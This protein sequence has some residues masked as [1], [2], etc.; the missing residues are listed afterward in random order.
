VRSWCLHVG[1]DLGK[2]HQM[3]GELMPGLSRWQGGIDSEVR[4]TRSP[5]PLADT[6]LRLCWRWE[7]APWTDICVDERRPRLLQYA[8]RESGR[9]GDSWSVTPRPLRCHSNKSQNTVAARSGNSGVSN[10]IHDDDTD[11]GS[12]LLCALDPRPRR[13]RAE[14]HRKLPTAEPRGHNH[15]CDR[16]DTTQDTPHLLKMSW[17]TSWFSSSRNDKLSRGGALSSTSEAFSLPVSSP[18]TATHPDAFNSDSLVMNE[19]DSAG[20]PLRYSYPPGRSNPYG[21][22]PPGYALVFTYSLGRLP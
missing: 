1:R 18:T 15:D 3:S 4:F 2:S 14:F 17:F 9:R 20:G 5:R 7:C 12:S 10:T 22:F 19:P 16:N 13:P 8:Q 21:Y 6:A 11:S